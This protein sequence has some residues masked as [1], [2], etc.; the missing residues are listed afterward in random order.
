MRRHG[1]P[2]LAE[3]KLRTKFTKDYERGLPVSAV[4]DHSYHPRVQAALKPDIVVQC[5]QPQSLTV[6]MIHRNS[7]LLRNH[8]Y[9]AQFH[10]HTALHAPH[11]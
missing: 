1:L 3:K 5:T 7:M 2:S 8:V 11:D 10:L 9:K 6:S 4:E